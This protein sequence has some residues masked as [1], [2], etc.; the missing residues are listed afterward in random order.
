MY[1]LLLTREFNR[2]GANP[3][4]NIAP[5]GV[6][7]ANSVATNA[8]SSYLAFSPFPFDKLRVVY[9][10]LHFPSPHLFNTQIIIVFVC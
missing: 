1:I 9:F 7:T 4:L 6:C 8:V 5:D 2:Q 3:L 10:L